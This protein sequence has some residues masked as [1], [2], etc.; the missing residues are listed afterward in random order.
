MPIKYN[1]SI[2][3]SNA[4]EMI[5]SPKLLREIKNY[6]LWLLNDVSKKP[7]YYS[8][9]NQGKII[10]TIE[11]SNGNILIF[12]HLINLLHAEI[13]VLDRQIQT[14]NDLV[15]ASSR[16]LFAI[17]SFS[18]VLSPKNKPIDQFMIILVQKL[19]IMTENL[20]QKTNELKEE[21][22]RKEEMFT[23]SSNSSVA[24]VTHFLSERDEV[25]P[26]HRRGFREYHQSQANQNQNRFFSIRNSFE[27]PSRNHRF[28]L[29]NERKMLNL[30]EDEIIKQPRSSEVRKIINILQRLYIPGASFIANFIQDM[31]WS[32]ESDER[33]NSPDR[34]S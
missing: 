22:Y 3:H 6:H 21:T 28:Q 24:T 19:H 14:I 2:I 33:V 15:L 34:L 1:E 9:L 25:E 17:H 20:I 10:D 27:I 8:R 4:E 11:A 13:T 12:M 26:S 30:L 23:L 5:F 32:F 31:I 18:A 29:E 7:G 16:I